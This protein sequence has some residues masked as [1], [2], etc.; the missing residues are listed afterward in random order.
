MSRLK[1]DTSVALCIIGEKKIPSQ[2]QPAAFPVRQMYFLSLEGTVSWD[3][4][5]RIPCCEAYIATFHC[6]LFC[7]T[8]RQLL[9]SGTKVGFG[10]GE[11]QRSSVG[12]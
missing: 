6:I 7:K 11:T 10:R 5:G 2:E 4:L 1:C 3:A 8:L 9:Y 12:A